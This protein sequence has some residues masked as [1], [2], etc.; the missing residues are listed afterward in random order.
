MID[1]VDLTFIIKAQET[2][3][4]ALPAADVTRLVL[5]AEDLRYRAA[6]LLPADAGLRVG[7]IRALLWSNLNG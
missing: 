1:S 5:A 3:M 7:E 4:V 2:D 6:I